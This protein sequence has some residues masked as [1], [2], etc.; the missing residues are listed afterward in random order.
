MEEQLD[1]KQNRMINFTAQIF[2]RIFLHKVSLRKS[3][4][5]RAWFRFGSLKNAIIWETGHALI[6]KNV[7]LNFF[8]LPF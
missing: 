6:G 1:E 2:T 5:W 4:V 7:S 3:D 8:F